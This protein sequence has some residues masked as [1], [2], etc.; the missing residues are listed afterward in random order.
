[1]NLPPYDI[2]PTVSGNKIT[3]R[4]ILPSDIKDILEISFYDSVQATTIEQ[5]AEMQ[6]KINKDYLDGNSIHLGYCR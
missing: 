4:Q 1:M 6:D 5:A 3:L 2:F